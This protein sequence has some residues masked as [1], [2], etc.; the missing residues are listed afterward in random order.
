MRWN[1]VVTWRTA[2]MWSR[3]RHAERRQRRSAG[4]STYLK[5]PSA[6][7]LCTAK[8]PPPCSKMM[9]C[10]PRPS[11]LFIPC[12][13]LLRVALCRACLEIL[14]QWIILVRVPCILT[15]QM[16]AATAPLC[17]GASGAAD[18]AGPRA[19]RHLLESLQTHVKYLRWD[20]CGP[21]EAQHP[22]QDPRKPQE[23]HGCRFMGNS[24][25]CER[26][27]AAPTQVTLCTY[28]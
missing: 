8:G 16:H 21:R 13:T 20:C 26:R 23:V 25:R 19:G 1:G 4:R 12:T 14:Q 22:P 28:S 27:V 11:L 2:G 15:A 6:S 5:T 9:P 17:R 7:V 18:Q 24:P 10:L 3:Q